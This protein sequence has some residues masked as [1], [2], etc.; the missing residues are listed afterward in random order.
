[1]Y[2]KNY[3]FLLGRAE[4]GHEE[5]LKG[6]RVTSCRDIFTTTSHVSRHTEE[7]SRKVKL[8]EALFFREGNNFPSSFPL[9]P[10]VN[11]ARNNFL[12]STFHKRIVIIR[13]II[14]K[15]IEF[16]FPLTRFQFKEL[17]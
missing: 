1:M 11:N 14:V 7:K 12:Q 10:Y 8:N 3:C 13:V 15:K 16:P 9:K 2:V 17:K 5:E 6:T 4:E